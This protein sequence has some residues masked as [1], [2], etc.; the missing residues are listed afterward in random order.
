MKKL[1][2]IAAGWMSMPVAECDVGDE[3]RQQRC[4]S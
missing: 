2:P 3:P 1:G 4:S